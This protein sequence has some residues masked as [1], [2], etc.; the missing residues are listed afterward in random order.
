MDAFAGSEGN[1][2]SG[3]RHRRVAGEWKSIKSGGILIRS[4]RFVEFDITGNTGR[5]GNMLGNESSLPF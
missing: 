3:G 5:D 4:F 2:M 1:A